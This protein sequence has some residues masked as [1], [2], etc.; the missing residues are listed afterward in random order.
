MQLLVSFEEKFGEGVQVLNLTSILEVE[1]KSLVLNL[2]V[3]LINNERHHN[4]N[5]VLE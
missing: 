4:S 3:I 1:T 5:I 2:I